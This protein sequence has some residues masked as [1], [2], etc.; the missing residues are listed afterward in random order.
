M[1]NNVAPK[2]AN[3]RYTP[4]AILLTGAAVFCVLVLFGIA[5]S[6]FLRPDAVAAAACRQFARRYGVHTIAFVPAGHRSR[7]SEGRLPNVDLRYDPRLPMENPNAGLV[8]SPRPA[9]YIFS[10]SPPV[11][12]QI[13]A[14]GIE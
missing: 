10:A 6:R 14:K 5:G 7:Y 9:R 4:A 2:T 3:D 1:K 8:F 13:G 12:K 11:E